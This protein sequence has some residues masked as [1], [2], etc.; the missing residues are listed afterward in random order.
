MSARRIKQIKRVMRKA[1]TANFVSMF[2]ELCDERFRLR[3][4]YAWRI[5]RRRKIGA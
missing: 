2:N 5:L 1:R 4:V 3:L